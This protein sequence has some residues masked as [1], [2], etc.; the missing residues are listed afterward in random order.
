MSKTRPLGGFAKKSEIMSFIVLKI[1]KTAVLQVVWVER[2]QS[3]SRD[4]RY[5]RKLIA[6]IQVRDDYGFGLGMR[7]GGS[8]V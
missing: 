3:G 2:D 1:R 5:M 8:E 7:S 4:I 6:I